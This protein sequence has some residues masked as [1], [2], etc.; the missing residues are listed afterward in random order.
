MQRDSTLDQKVGR[1][2]DLGGIEP[3]LL[4]LGGDLW[5]RDQ[6]HPSDLSP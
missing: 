5:E 1:T 2:A 3:V 6:R 4:W